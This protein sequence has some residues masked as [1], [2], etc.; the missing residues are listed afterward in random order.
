LILSDDT[1]SPKAESWFAT[2][3]EVYPR[4]RK[5][6]E[7]SAV[8]PVCGLQLCKFHDPSPGSAAP[9]YERISVYLEGTWC[10]NKVHQYFDLELAGYVTTG[11]A[12]GARGAVRKPSS[13]GGTASPATGA[14]KLR[15]PGAG[16][17]GRISP[18]SA[19][20]AE[21]AGEGFPG[22]K[23]QP[24][25]FPSGAVFS[26]EEVPKIGRFQ[27]VRCSRPAV[28]ARSAATRREASQSSARPGRAIVPPGVWVAWRRGHGRRCGR[29]AGRGRDGWGWTLGCPD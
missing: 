15:G 18:Q 16:R 12:P 6:H 4:T 20:D 27:T 26:V 21:D 7:K 29:G 2:F 9:C 19:E 14:A 10:A 8:S 24:F 22:S 5:C 11:A 13:R 28:G 25:L 3:G 23:S 17:A 1:R